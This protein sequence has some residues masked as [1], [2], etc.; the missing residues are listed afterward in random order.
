MKLIQ[1]FLPLIVPF[2]T[3]SQHTEIYEGLT[4]EL[5]FKTF[6]RSTSTEELIGDS[7]SGHGYYYFQVDNAQVVGKQGHLQL[8]FN[9][10]RLMIPLGVGFIHIDEEL[11]GSEHGG[12]NLT[13]TPG[14]FASSFTFKRYSDYGTIYTGF[15]VNVLPSKEKVFLGPII[16]AN[17]L[18]LFRHVITE[19]ESTYTQYEATDYVEQ[20]KGA[21]HSIRPSVGVLFRLNTQLGLQFNLEAGYNRLNNNAASYNYVEAIKGSAYAQFSIGYDFSKQA[22]K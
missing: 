19:N 13:T 12:Y 22:K 5:G 10:D 1:L 7:G 15:G 17:Y 11:R 4:L 8:N 14:Y 21:K 16:R 2:A 9:F 3:F 20:G 6:A 18:Y